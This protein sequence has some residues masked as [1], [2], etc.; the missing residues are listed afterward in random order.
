MWNE[1]YNNDF[2]KVDLHHISTFADSI[3]SLNVQINALNHFMQ[4]VIIHSIRKIV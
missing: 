1:S 2:V 4:H 3:F